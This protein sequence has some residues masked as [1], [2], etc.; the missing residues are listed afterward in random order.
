MPGIRVGGLLILLL[1]SLLACDNLLG[2][3]NPG[4]V[5]ADDLDNSAGGVC[6]LLDD[7]AGRGMV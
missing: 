4:S 5:D 2:V 6:R 1:P 3:S 7:A